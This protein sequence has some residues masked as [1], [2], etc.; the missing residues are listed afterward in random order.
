[1]SFAS[2]NLLHVHIREAKC[3]KQTILTNL[4]NSKIQNIVKIITF[5]ASIK[6]QSSELKFRSWNFLQTFIKFISTMKTIL[7][8]LNIECD[9]TL[10][11][12]TWILSLLSNIRIKKMQ[13]SLRVKDI[14]SF[15]HEFVEYVCISVYFSDLTKNDFSALT[16][17]ARKIHLINDLK[18]KMLI[19][20]DLLNSKDFII[21]IEKKSTTIESCEINISLKIQSKE[22]YIRK[23]VHAQ[24]IVVLLSSEKQLISIKIKIFENRNFFFESDA[25]AN[26]T[27]CSHILNTNTKQILIKNEFVNIVKISRRI[28]LN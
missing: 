8:C 2:R 23:I 6:D 22:S 17:I 4:D 10:A 19:E 12:K 1:M 26:F 16:F 25:N 28:R 27:M 18:V 7:I 13:T 20:N 24:N 21:D 15:T 11:D 3:L 14:K 5:K 9:A